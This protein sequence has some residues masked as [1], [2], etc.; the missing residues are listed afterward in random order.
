MNRSSSSIRR[1]TTRALS[2]AP[3]HDAGRSPRVGSADTI[4]RWCAGTAVSFG[5]LHL[6]ESPLHLSEGPLHRREA[7]VHLSE[8][9]LHHR[10]A[11]V[12]LEASDLRRRASHSASSVASSAESFTGMH[13]QYH[14]MTS[15]CDCDAATLLR[16]ATQSD[17]RAD[18]LDR[19]TG[20]RGPS[21]GPVA[22]HAVLRGAIAS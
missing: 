1:K 16:G 3:D 10:E 17:R 6:R 7:P 22:V 14:G 8:G 4:G 5:P 18:T 11:P 12:H 20:A 21:A 15:H 2:A 19:I 9:P 13:C